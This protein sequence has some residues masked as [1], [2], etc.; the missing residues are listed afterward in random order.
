MP[1]G[2][3][4]APVGAAA[5][6]ARQ[7]GALFADRRILRASRR[8]AL[9]RPQRGERAALPLSRLEIRP[10]RPMYRSAFGAGGKRLLQEDQAEIL[11]AGRAWRISLDLYGP[12][13]KT[14]AF[15]GIRGRAGAARAALHQ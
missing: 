7:P 6:M 4:E 10:Y 3:G 12:A 15:A 1:A 14:A 5:R 11:S 9:V 13:R 2:P 8:L